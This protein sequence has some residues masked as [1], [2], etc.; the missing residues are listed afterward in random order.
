MIFVIQMGSFP[1]QQ[2]T[3]SHH[4]KVLPRE[5]SFNWCCDNDGFCK[6]VI[7]EE[8]NDEVDNVALLL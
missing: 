5:S 2:G 7:V 6:K 8:C 3:M 1:Y 4:A